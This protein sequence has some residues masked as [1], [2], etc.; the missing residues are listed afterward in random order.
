MQ[1]ARPLTDLAILLHE[2]DNVA[3]ALVDVPAGEYA[4]P[5][6]RG[7][8]AITVPEDIAAGFKLAVAPIAAGGQV[9]KYGHRIG[10]AT[11]D[12]RP[13]ECVHVHNLASGV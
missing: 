13:G 8:E 10:T 9:T 11:V 6:G 4:L 7:G 1:A 12:I 3:T 2:A 5:A